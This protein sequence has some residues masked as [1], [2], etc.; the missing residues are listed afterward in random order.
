MIQKGTRCNICTGCGRCFGGES[1]M[2]IVAEG[3]LLALWQEQLLAGIFG[4]PEFRTKQ[5]TR[6]KTG[7]FGYWYRYL[8]MR[9]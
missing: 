7:E 3:G 2:R 4:F 6:Q 8:D 5:V 9:K 1:G